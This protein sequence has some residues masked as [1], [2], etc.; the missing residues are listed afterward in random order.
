MLLLWVLQDLALPS[1]GFH[2]LREVGE[3][4]LPAGRLGAWRHLVVTVSPTVLS[5]R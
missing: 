2:P 4:G 3:Q 5:S 1:L